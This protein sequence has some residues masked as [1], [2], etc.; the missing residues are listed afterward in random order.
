MVFLLKAKQDGNY[1]STAVI[2]LG[3]R[4]NTSEMNQYTQAM[5]FISKKKVFGKI[6]LWKGQQG[7][8]HVH[9]VDSVLIMCHQNLVVEQ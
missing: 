3:V 8:F 9:S 4:N 5:R 6:K 2:W 7:S 1:W